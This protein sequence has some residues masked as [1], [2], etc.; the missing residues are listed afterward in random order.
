MIKGI[1]LDIDNTLYDYNEAHNKGLN[2]VYD[3]AS[4]LF[5]R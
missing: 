4:L 2:A 3:F 1:L 5:D